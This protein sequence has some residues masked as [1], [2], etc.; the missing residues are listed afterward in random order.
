MLGIDLGSSI[1]T[2][3]IRDQ[4]PLAADTTC[5]NLRQYNE[6]ADV[7]AL[8]AALRGMVPTL[9]AVAGYS[10][11]A[12]VA[13]MR[14][15]GMV[16]GSIKRH[17]PEPVPLAPEVVPVLHELGRRTD[18]VPRDTVHHYTTWNPVGGRQ[19]M[20]TG[21]IQEAYLQESVRMVFPHLRE[22]LELAGLLSDTDVAEPKVADLTDELTGHVE[23]MVSAIDMVVANV[24]PEFFARDLRSYFE[25]ITVDGRVLLGPAAAQVP[26]WLIDQAVWASDHSG[27]EY[28]EFLRDSVPYSLP[29]WRELYDCWTGVPSVVTRL[30]AAYGDDPDGAERR[31]PGLRPAAEA[32][33]RLLR[34]VLV[35]RGRHLGIARKAYDADLRLYPVGSGGASVDLLRQ[36]TDLTRASAQLTRPRG[37]SAE[38]A[39]RR[40]A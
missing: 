18:M 22:A 38:R 30:V 11:E 19:R 35:F 8:T 29:R 37:G 14:D 15:L 4:D 27:P 5:F 32:L 33:A 16:L 12:C 36:I 1:R 10:V 13:A 28:Q 2:A 9:D 34:V 6:H 25:E 3:A 20:Y 17:G 39:E 24:S 40:P 21:D 23:V 31:M 7:P 26:L